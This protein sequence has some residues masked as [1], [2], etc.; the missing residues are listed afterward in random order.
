MRSQGILIKLEMELLRELYHLKI[1][2]RVEWKESGGK[3]NDSEDESEFIG[4]Q[5]GKERTEGRKENRILNSTAIGVAF[6]FLTFPVP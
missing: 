5:Y 4:L 6:H 2:H 3:Y 1:I